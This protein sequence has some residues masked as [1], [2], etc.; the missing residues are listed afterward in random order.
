MECVEDQEFI[1]KLAIKWAPE[2]RLYSKEKCRPSST[3]W[4]IAH[5]DLMFVPFGAD[6]KDIGKH[7]VVLT[8]KELAANPALLTEQTV[9]KRDGKG[10]VYSGIKDREEVKKLSTAIGKQVDCLNERWYIRLAS[11]EAR[12]G[13]PR[14][15]IEAGKVPI[16]A[17][18][19][20]YARFHPDYPEAPRDLDKKSYKKGDLCYEIQYYFCYPFNGEEFNKG[21]SFLSSMGV[22]EGD[23]EHCT[24]RVTPDGEDMLALYCSAHSTEGQWYLK[25]ATN[26]SSQDG[27]QTSEGR[28]GP[29]VWIGNGGHALW[30]WTG[31]HSRNVQAD[32]LPASG[33]VSSFTNLVKVPEFILADETDNGGI[34]W[35][36]WKNV[37]VCNI[38]ADPLKKQ[39]HKVDADSGR[40]VTL[41]TQ[42][43]LF[44]LTFRGRWGTHYLPGPGTCSGPSG[45]LFKDG[46][47]LG[48]ESDDPLRKVTTIPDWCFE[49]YQR[50]KSDLV[51]CGFRGRDQSNLNLFVE[52]IKPRFEVSTDK[53]KRVHTG[54]FKKLVTTFGDED[55]DSDEITFQTKDISSSGPRPDRGGALPAG[56][57]LPPELQGSG[58]NAFYLPPSS[59]GF[60]QVPAS[61]GFA[62]ASSPSTGGFPQ[63]PSSVGF[64][65]GY[66]V[67]TPP[68]LDHK[69]QA[70]ANPL[71]QSAPPSAGRSFYNQGDSDNDHSS[72]RPASSYNQAVISSSSSN[73]NTSPSP[74]SPYNQG[75]AND[76]HSSTSSRPS[77]SASYNQGTST[78]YNQGASANYN[79]GNNDSSHGWA[80]PPNP[81]YL[82]SMSGGSAPSSSSA[83]SQ[84]AQSAY[85]TSNPGQSSPFAAPPN[86]NYL[87]GYGASSSGKSQSMYA[88]VG[89]S[90][91]V[92]SPAS[93]FASPPVEER[94]YTPPDSPNVAP[95]GNPGNL[96]APTNPL[97]SSDASLRKK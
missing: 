52:T 61:G 33:L 22:H 30:A 69:A 41:F 90:T 55:H 35:K 29:I 39:I 13:Q 23:W 34:N 64:R 63:I 84:R 1:R 85:A 42:S 37:V 79:Q 21:P 81:N 50:M 70:Q 48:D 20:K 66:G 91:G 57:Y 68:E 49:P 4:F 87:P 75:P 76:N 7:K 62:Q 2:A 78:N 77:T 60:P 71:R 82:P 14:E 51:T 8:S 44:W 86:P 15:E 72:S 74:S 54:P 92:S 93:G 95:A 65:S 94:F 31:S 47:M 89:Y 9:P 45:P 53:S 6:Y 3:E 80:A 19:V 97:R 56:Y 38:W 59:G 96:T 67:F 25:R 5:S 27:W 73:S 12:D 17:H 58:A 40:G 83:S 24:V 46:F 43:D 11:P 36:T 26:S 88:P 16:Y 10:K 28:K 18:V 32:Q